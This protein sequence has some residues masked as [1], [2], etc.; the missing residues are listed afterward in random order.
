MKI[1]ALKALVAAIEEG[2][3]RGAARRLGT[4]QPALTKLVREL[5]IE[6]AAPLL[7]RHSKGVMMRTALLGKVCA[8]AAKVKPKARTEK[9]RRIMS[10][11]S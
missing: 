3:L 7:D 11:V 8:C 1:S 9:M 4:S 6:L 2:S 10:K 5:E